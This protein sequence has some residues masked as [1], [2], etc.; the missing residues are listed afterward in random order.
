MKWMRLII[1]P[2]LASTVVLAGESSVQVSTTSVTNR[3]QQI[4]PEGWLMKFAKTNETSTSI[5]FAIRGK[6]YGK[7]QVE[8]VIYLMPTNYVPNPDP[9]ESERQS[10]SPRLLGDTSEYRVFI[11]GWWLS[12]QWPTMKE[13]ILG[14]LSEKTQV[15]NQSSQVT[16]A[17]M[18]KPE[19]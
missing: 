6:E 10:P 4:L 15:S 19:R 11:W 17:P 12:R 18:P 1:L 16:V 14:A 5:G 3:L 8:C 7:Q 13:D 9:H 2:A